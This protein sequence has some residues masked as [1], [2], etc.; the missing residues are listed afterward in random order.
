M[1]TV[2]M[3]G[4]SLRFMLASWNSYSKSETAR[5]PR[6]N[7]FTWRCLAYSTSRPWKA[8]TSTRGSGQA[9]RMSSR[10]SSRVKSGTFFGFTAMA[11]ITRSNI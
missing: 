2:S 8:S 4:A 6:S 7:T 9:W 11:T 3:P 5:S 1:K 10:R